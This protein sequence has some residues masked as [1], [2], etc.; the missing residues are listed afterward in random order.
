MRTW[1]HLFASLCVFIATVIVGEGL[2][3]DDLANE[4]RT[5][6]EQAGVAQVPGPN[7]WH[8]LREVNPPP[9]A[10]DGNVILILGATL[11]D[12]RGG[13]PI[14]NS[15]VLVRGGTIAGVGRAGELEVPPGAT[16][17]DAAG[18]TLLPGLIDAHLHVGESPRAILGRPT[19]V[20]THGVT[21]ARD[22]GRAI[23]DYA[24]ALASGRPLPRLFLTGKHFDQQPH[25]HPHNALDIQTTEQAIAAVDRIVEQGGSAIKVYYRLPPELIAATCRRADHHGIPVTAH[26][27]LIDADAAIAAGVD[28]LEHVTS[29]GTVLA[30]PEAAEAFRQ[31]VE[32]DNEARRSW[33]FRLW[34]AVDLEHPRTHEH[35]ALLAD[36]GIY[37][38]PTLNVFERR[39]GDAAGSEA[40]HVEGFQ[41]MLRFVGMCHRAGVPIVA[42]SHGTPAG[43][44]EGWAMQHEMRLIGESGLTPLEVITSAT[45]TPAHFFGCAERLGSIEPGKQADLV[46]YDGRPHEDLDDLWTVNRVMQAG[47]WV[48]PE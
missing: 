33:R 30:E 34:A 29:C 27:E 14:E 2:S 17:V 47:Q 4:S 42:S 22:P 20:L 19:L 6:Q 37:L 15:A 24:P 18:Q 13:P 5:A 3:A 48:A 31:S 32:A 12:G 43:C 8:G 36:R 1:Q 44:E 41:K 10:D 46:L 7:E 21:A 45:L 23:E 39:E 16:V 25:A 40:Y 26:L 9:S 35:I 28:G 38:T 11:V